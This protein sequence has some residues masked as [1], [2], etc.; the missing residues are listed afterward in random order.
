MY[1]TLLNRIHYNIWL[2]KIHHCLTNR[3]TQLHFRHLNL[4][5]L[6]SSKFMPQTKRRFQLSQYFH[7]FRF[8]LLDPLRNLLEGHL[9]IR[10]K[11][12]SFS[13]YLNN[14]NRGVDAVLHQEVL[15]DGVT[16]VL[17]NT[18]YTPSRLFFP[19]ASVYNSAIVYQQ[20]IIVIDLNFYLGQR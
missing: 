12:V 6:I 16:S 19:Q 3:Q 8:C 13:N 17:V 9:R 20:K 4:K 11:E 18:S 1:I 15:D 2:T 5:I 7:Q 10:N 14:W